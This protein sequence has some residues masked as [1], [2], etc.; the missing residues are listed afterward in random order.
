MR[1]ALY[2]RYSSDL[3]REASIEDQER[4]CRALATERGWQVSAVYGDRATS[5]STKFR[6]E[7]QRLLADVRTG[8]F[9]VV[10]AEALDRLS[11][12]QEDVAALY[13]ALTFAGV[14]LVTV[15]E[16][17]ISELHV[18]LKGTMNALFLKDLA[19]K[20]HRGLQGRVEQ[21]RSAGGR[22]FGYR[23]AREIDANGDPV[24]GGRE[25]DLNEAAVVQRIFR[26]F[27]D[28]TSPRAIAKRL[29]TEK[30]AG[31]G[32]RPWLDTTLRGH[33]V[34]GTGILRNELYAGRLVWNRQHFIKDPATGKRQARPNPPSEWVIEDVPELR[35]INDGLW[36]RV[37]DRL[38]AIAATPRATALRKGGFWQ[39]RRPRHFLTGLVVCGCCGH[40]LAATGRDYLGCQRAHRA[41]LCTNKTSVKRGA[42]EDIVIRALQHN[43][44]Q[45]EAV[46]EFTRALHEE[47]NT[48]R[49]QETHDRR[50]QEK[51]LA[52]VERQLDSLITAIAN[53]LRSSGLQQRLDGL[54]SEKAEL[55]RVLAA[56]PPSPVRLHPN[57][58]ALY[59]DKV[60]ALRE[61]LQREDTRA[62]AFGILRGLVEKVAVSPREGGGVEVELVG[63]IASMVRLA[64]DGDGPERKKAAPGRTALDGGFVRSVKVVAGTRNHRELTLRCPI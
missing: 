23:V 60:A 46:E 20:T 27:A 7:Y 3:Q 51:R 26:E 58:A 45:P 4:I 30:I 1:V 48:A 9:D 49:A 57:L 13:K 56:P 52:E 33:A 32:G 40:A 22:C 59:R 41:G 63:E 16:G 43:L 47:L 31:P 55:T 25:I 62:E 38:G 5:G 18:G 29:N 54:E 28:G 2:S 44:M 10:V 37:C 50:R 35:I 17:E 19:A 39:H 53:G 11:R 36:Q 24:R 8:K 15:A 61:A 42:L 21:G 34:R 6:P 12:D 64:L 14:K